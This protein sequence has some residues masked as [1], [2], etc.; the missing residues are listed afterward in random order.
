LKHNWYYCSDGNA[1]CGRAGR[2]RLKKDGKGSVR[3][4]MQQQILGFPAAMVDHI[5]GDPTDNRKINLRVCTSLENHRNLHAHKASQ[6]GYIGVLLCNN[7]Y[8]AKIVHC[9]KIHRLGAFDTPEEAAV[10]RDMKAIELRGAFANLNFPTLAGIDT[11]EV[12]ASEI[13]MTKHKR[14]RSSFVY[15]LK[16][17]AEKMVR[18]MISITENNVKFLRSTANKKGISVSEL[19]RRI[20]DYGEKEMSAK[21]ERRS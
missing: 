10:A 1:G 18:R 2:R 20:I 8:R 16:K 3:I 14:K 9:G 4:F 12:K 21:K 17:T 11:H 15:T 6:S 13:D 19:L 5:N 7:R